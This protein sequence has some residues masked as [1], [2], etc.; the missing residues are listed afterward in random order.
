MGFAIIVL[1]RGLPVEETPFQNI[2]V[3]TE[4]DCNFMRIIAFWGLVFEVL[5]CIQDTFA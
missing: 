3:R 5:F 1:F 2:M 4:Y